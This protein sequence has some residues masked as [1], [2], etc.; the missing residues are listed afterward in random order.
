MVLLGFNELAG[1]HLHITVAVVERNV[2]H[3]CYRKMFPVFKHE[4]PG[5]AFPV[6]TRNGLKF[7]IVICADGSYIEPCRILALR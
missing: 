7:G 4:T 3:G 1:D 5:N 2:I 6:F